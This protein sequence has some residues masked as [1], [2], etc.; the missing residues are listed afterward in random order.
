MILG[1]ILLLFFIIFQSTSQNRKLCLDCTGVGGLHVR[2]SSGT[3]V[4]MFVFMF[5]CFFLQ[6]GFL[7]TFDGPRT[8]FD[9][10]FGDLFG[11]KVHKKAIFEGSKTSAQKSWKKGTKSN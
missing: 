5:F 7:S 2:P 10:H 8:T 11:Q 3:S 9:L 4:F 6:C 1:V